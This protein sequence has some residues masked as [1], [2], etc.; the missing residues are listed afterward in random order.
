MGEKRTGPECRTVL[1]RRSLGT[2]ADVTLRSSIVAN[3]ANGGDFSGTVNDAGYNLCS[4]G[5][6]GFS[7][8]GSLNQVDPMLSALSQNGGPTPSMAL[9][10]AARHGT[11]FRQGF[12]QP[13]S[14]GSLG[15]K[16]LRQTWGGGS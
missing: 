13:I 11:P 9:L 3:N 10:A 8:I 6:A 4:D 1:G 16:D 7:G 12:R 5:T 2:N 14:G 15:R